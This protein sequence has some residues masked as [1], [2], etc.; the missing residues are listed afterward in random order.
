MHNQYKDK[1]IYQIIM[2]SSNRMKWIK[3]DEGNWKRTNQSSG[4][5][6]FKTCVKRYLLQLRRDYKYY[7]K[8]FRY[9]KETSVCKCSK[10]GDIGHSKKICYSLKYYWTLLD[11]I[12]DCEYLIKRGYTYLPDNIVE[13][14]NKMLVIQN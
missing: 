2:S 7:H 10:C 6:G 8:K 9:R 4:I 13:I 11:T 14:N 5:L 1:A 12:R 3:D